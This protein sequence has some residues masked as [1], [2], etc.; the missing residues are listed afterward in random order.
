VVDGSTIGLFVGKP[1]SS[2]T[3]SQVLMT[4]RHAIALGAAM[5]LAFALSSALL[6]SRQRP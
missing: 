5:G 3:N 2:L 6:R 1:D 4:G